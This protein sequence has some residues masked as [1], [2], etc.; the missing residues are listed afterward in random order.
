[1][2]AELKDAGEGRLSLSG[3][4]DFDS[5][6]D[7]YRQMA[8]YLAQGGRLSLNLEHVGRFNSAGLALLLQWIEDARRRKV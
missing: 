2:P 7:V 1:M 3:A 4:I 5:V 8:P 6:A